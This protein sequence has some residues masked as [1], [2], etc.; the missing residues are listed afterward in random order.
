[1]ESPICAEKV[2]GQME[3]YPRRKSCLEPGES[4]LVWEKIL[5]G[6]DGDSLRSEMDCLKP[7]GTAERQAKVAVPVVLWMLRGWV[8][9]FQI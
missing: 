3:S 7:P 5:P 2:P 9:L 1:M 6:L 4:E 8:T